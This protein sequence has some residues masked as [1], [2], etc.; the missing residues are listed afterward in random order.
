M[1]AMSNGTIFFDF[2]LSE[3]LSTCCDVLDER[4]LAS[5]PGDPDVT[6]LLKNLIGSF[7]DEIRIELCGLCS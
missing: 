4:G 6:D 3:I 2:R 7:G 5:F 1:S